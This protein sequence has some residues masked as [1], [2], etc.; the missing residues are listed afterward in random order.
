VRTAPL[1]YDAA[2]RLCESLN[3]VIGSRFGCISSSRRSASQSDS[4]VR[5]KTVIA[6]VWIGHRGGF[7]IVGLLCVS[8]CLANSAG[9]ICL[10]K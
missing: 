6:K 7:L 5:G 10:K 3:V 2:C 8:R 9:G 4:L 1:Y